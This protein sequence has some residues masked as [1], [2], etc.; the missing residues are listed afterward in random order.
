[1]IRS[2]M[3]HNV[4]VIPLDNRDRRNVPQWMGESRGRWEGDTLVVETGSFLDRSAR[5]VGDGVA[6]QPADAAP[7]RTL[8]AHRRRDARLRVHDD[9][10]D[11]VHAAVDGA[12][13]TDH[14]PGGARRHEGTA[15]R[16]RLPRR[17]LQP[18]QRLARGTVAGTGLV[19][20]RTAKSA[21]SQEQFSASQTFGK[22]IHLRRASFDGPVSRERVG[23]EARPQHPFD[24]VPAKM[25]DAAVAD[26][27]P[28]AAAPR[29]EH[30]RQDAPR[31]RRRCCL[32]AARTCA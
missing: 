31:R 10:S 23:P 2:E 11:D 12:I 30:L 32:A 17:E 21:G 16:I 8:H 26:V 27:E 13:P 3:Y 7:D 24:D 28:H 14:Q 1:M 18:R 15:P 22:S 20:K 25:A 9:R 5:L 29:G 19:R 4:R 6:S